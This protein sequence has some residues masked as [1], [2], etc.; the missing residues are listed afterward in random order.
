[1][2]LWLRIPASLSEDSD[3]GPRSHLITACNRS[4]RVPH[5]CSMAQAHTYAIHTGLCGY[6]HLW[7]QWIR[8]IVQ[9][10]A[11][12]APRILGDFSA[13][14]NVGNYYI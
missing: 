8:G 3:S 14:N 5:A 11:F 6:C 9:D 7:T 1:M 13:S 10:L 4:S 12:A 2:A